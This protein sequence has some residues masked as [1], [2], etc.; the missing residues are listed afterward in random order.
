MA[1]RR[2]LLALSAFLVLSSSLVPRTAHPQDVRCDP[3]DVEVLRLRFSGNHAFTAADLSKIIVTTPSAWARRIL[4]L[5]FTERRCLDRA[6]LP[7]DRARLIIFYRLRGYPRVMVDTALR[8]IGA[9]G[10]EVSFTIHEGPPAVL[11]SFVV[12]G[13]SAVTDGGRIARGI[14]PRAGGRFD[15]IAIGAASDTIARQ[16][17]NSGYPLARTTN[18]FALADSGLSAWDTLTVTPGPLTRIGRLN[19]SVIPLAGTSQKIPTPAVRRVMGIRTND[20]YREDEIIGA[21]RALYQ[22]EAYEHVSI[23]PDTAMRPTDSV[24]N[25]DV[26]LS[27]AA[28]HAARL[29]AGY[30]TLDCFRVT[31]ELS[32]YNFLQGA[33][34]LDFTARVSK[35]GIG[36]PLSGAEQLCPQAKRDVFSNRLN[37]YIGSTLRQPVFFGLRTV[38]TVTV[39][40]QRVSEYNAYLRTTAIGGL[41]SLAWQRWKR[42]PV[43]IAYS[44]DLGRTE[45]QP[46]LFCAVFNVCDL[47]ARERLQATQ[48]LAVLSTS[49]TRDN[50]N[51][52][53]NPT[54]GSVIRFEARHSSPAIFS[55]QGLTFSK[56]VGDASRY[57]GLGAGNVFAVRVRGGIVVGRTIGQAAGFVPPQERLYAGGPTSVRGFA[58]NELGSVIYIASGFVPVALAT[59]DTVFRVADSVRTFRRLVPVGGNTLAVGNVEL[60]L[61]SPILPELLQW[62]LF[63]DAGEVWNRGG[64]SVSEAVRFKVTP[65]I[66]LTAF[67]PVGPVRAVIGYNGYPR[68]AGPLYYE[69]TAAQGGGLPCVSPGNTIPAHV[70]SG[71]NAGVLAQAPGVCPATFKPPSQTSFRSRLTFSFAI[72]QAF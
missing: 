38:P 26:T 47:E 5:P 68:P 71:S 56:L 72:G 55:D 15:R 28:M 37:Y 42:T 21:Q 19:I 1:A 67:S 2:T 3:G 52:V 51:S 35:I 39:Y 53:L 46:A 58:Q 50:A 11:R 16:L 64:R 33:R 10:V 6:E 31:G 30:G 13:M 54:R 63:T 17:R 44:L 45:A 12:N 22:T 49:I 25:L 60:R 40:S 18:S 66:Q 4:P 41:A 62:T 70:G 36:K 32:N 43:N 48:R 29:G 59:G 65:G 9:H 8:A 34:R 57:W 69:A 24:I 20:L 14:G 27:E 23:A 61:K 7:N